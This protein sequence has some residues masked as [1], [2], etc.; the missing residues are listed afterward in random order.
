MR[1]IKLLSLWWIFWLLSALLNTGLTYAPNSSIIPTLIFVGGMIFGGKLSSLTPGNKVHYDLDSKIVVHIISLLII[2]SM[3]LLLP[4]IY[5]VAKGLISGVSFLHIRHMIFSGNEI[6]V[7]EKFIFNVSSALILNLSMVLSV[8]TCFLY[9]NNKVFF[10]CLLLI[11]TLGL[12]RVG[13]VEIYQFLMVYLFMFFILNPGKILY[14][15]KIKFKK[16]LIM[17]TLVIVVMACISLGR[18][19]DIITGFINYHT[20][21]FYLFS[22]Y[23]NGLPDVVVDTKSYG[24]SYFGGID[25]VV[26]LLGKLFFN[27]GDSFS[28]H[29]SIIESV[30]RV[31]HTREMITSNGI[32]YAMSGHNTYYTLLM[33]GYLSFGLFGVLLLGCVLGFLITELSKNSADGCI[34]SVIF[35]TMLVSMVFMGIF[36]NPLNTIGFWIT[37]L[38]LNMAL[39]TARIIKLRL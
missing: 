31:T 25:Y 23:I 22:K 12:I 1:A 37:I 16:I 6:G 14:F 4:T 32:M 28:Y 9:K 5:I 34:L 18:G 17:M 7:Y 36:Y 13:R 38:I 29:N 39:V 33:S 10:L 35:L 24:V 19:H 27:M 20:V 26:G 30:D 3:F 21:G 8:I 2:I 11:C 15:L